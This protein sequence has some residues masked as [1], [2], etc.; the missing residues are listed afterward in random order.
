[1]TLGQRIRKIRRALDLTQ[2][3]FGEHICVKGN[4]VAQWESGRNNSPDYAIAFICREFHVSEEW[5]R[6]ET[7]EMFI[8][9]ANDEIKALAKRY[10]LS[11]ADQVLIEKFVN[12]PKEFRTAVTN[13]ILEATSTILHSRTEESNN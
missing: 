12:S 8:S 3:N 13:M 2:E 10:N 11:C 1:M 7:G 5:L 6:N 9:E 4:T